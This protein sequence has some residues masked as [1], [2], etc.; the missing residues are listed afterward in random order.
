V[1]DAE[2][3]FGL[4]E[5]E[6]FAPDEEDEVFDLTLPHIPTLLGP[7]A[8]ESLGPVLFVAET[9][10]RDASG[11]SD[12]GLTI[13]DLTEASQHGLG[14]VVSLSAGGSV[15]AAELRW[16]AERTPVHHL[17][18]AE[19]GDAG[20]RAGLTSIRPRDEAG[21]LQGLDAA[22]R[23]PVAIDASGMGVTAIS[24]LV[25]TIVETCPR[26]IVW[27][28]DPE[29]GAEALLDV[30]ESGVFVLLERIIDED[31]YGDAARA[32]ARRVV[33]EGY[34]CLLLMGAPVEASRAGPGRE[35]MRFSAVMQW[36]P[37]LL[38][39]SGLTAAD[40][41]AILIENPVRVLTRPESGGETTG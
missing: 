2:H 3:D 33:Q 14:A 22:R 41:R 18:G 34:G 5:G 20:E 21:M 38:M 37:V 15:D 8:P 32:L 13:A 24:G 11:R 31:S 7:V 1:A 17:A 26:A 4:A 19:P 12:P 23:L 10:A 25:R 27:N 36:A 40:V 28:L 30:L 29:A 9:I 35:L 16:V 6:R 39:E